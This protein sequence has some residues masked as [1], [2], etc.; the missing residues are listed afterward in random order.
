[1]AAAQEVIKKFRQSS[2]ESIDELT[3]RLLEN[4][5]YGFDVVPAAIH[6]A[7]STLSM[8]ETSQLITEMKLWRMH[9]GVY[10]GV[11]RLGSLD[12]LETSQTLG[13]AQRLPLLSSDDGAQVTGEG[14]V[15]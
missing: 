10:K 7:A 9:H 1:M 5:L 8:S 14:G 13:N 11:P 3:K 2:S 12:M 4:V 6:L 15:S